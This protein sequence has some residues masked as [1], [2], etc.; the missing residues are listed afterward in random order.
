MTDFG[1]R[2]P[3]DPFFRIFRCPAELVS[4]E[5]VKGDH[6]F[7]E[8]SLKRGIAP[9]RQSAVTQIAFQTF[10]HPSHGR[11]LFH[12]SLKSCGHRRIPRIGMRRHAERHGDCP[13]VVRMRAAF[14]SVSAAR[15]FMP[16]GSPSVI[17]LILRGLRGVIRIM[18]KSFRKSSLSF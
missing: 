17:V 13:P 12:D 3:S 11:S 2:Y 16:R 10:Y 18:P 7:V 5:N 8:V 14:R 1:R 15:L 4:Q 9:F 6:R